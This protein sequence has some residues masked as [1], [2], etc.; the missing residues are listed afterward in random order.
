MHLDFNYWII[1]FL[2]V[3]HK[4]IDYLYANA[5][6]I[7]WYSFTSVNR[8]CEISFTFYLYHYHSSVELAFYNIVNGRKDL[9]RIVGG[10]IRN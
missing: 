10:K 8:Q 5:Q 7:E 2:V 4:I 6:C 3:S 9:L 1:T